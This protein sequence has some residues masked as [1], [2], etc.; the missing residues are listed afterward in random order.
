MIS[1]RYNNIFL[2]GGAFSF[3]FGVLFR[4]FWFIPWWVHVILCG[5]F[6]VFW[7]V[8]SKHNQVISLL[9]FVCIV[10]F[11]LGALRFSIKH[12]SIP[13]AMNQ[14]SVDE[15]VQ[16]TGRIVSE[17]ERRENSQRFVLRPDGQRQVKILVT[18]DRYPNAY[19]GETVSVS[20]TLRSPSNFI[21]DSGREFDYISYLAKDDIY[22]LL[23]F[24]DVL[25]RTPYKKKGVRSL[26]FSFKSSF[27]SSFERVVP[28]PESSLL[29]GILLGVKESLGDDLEQAFI[30]TGTIHIVVL[31]GYNVTIVSEAIVRNLAMIFSRNLSLA[32]GGIGIILFAIVT[33]ATTT[34]VRAS[35]MGLL[36]LLARFTGRTYEVSRIL[37]LAGLVMVLH[38]PF[39]LVF[40]ISFQLSFIATLGLIWISPIVKTWRISKFFTERF[41]VREI[42]A[43]TIATQIAVFPYLMYRIGTVSL[44]SPLANM[45]VLPI[46]PLSMGVGALTGLFELVFHV[47]SYPISWLSFGLLHYTVSIVKFLAS[48]SWSSIQSPFVPFSIIFFLYLYLIIWVIRMYRN[49]RIRKEL[50]RI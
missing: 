27:I 36:G 12:A 7:L 23:P 40:D 48:F 5:S 22:F 45:L 35:I 3:F 33:G 19:F 4:S 32:F 38:N 46:I 41:G 28:Y 21:T 50:V 29:S 9:I 18:T 26:L 30:D 47:G 37:L 11:N 49:P 42:F 24:A 1:A 2:Y 43:S 8:F 14:F 31:S 6:F 15:K 13:E 39:V 17:P 20:G 10:C 25:E 16:I 34:T 44:I